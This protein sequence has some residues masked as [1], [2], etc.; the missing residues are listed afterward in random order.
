MR[1]LTI[2]SFRHR[3]LAQARASLMVYEGEPDKRHCVTRSL[4]AGMDIGP[5][6][7]RFHRAGD[8]RNKFNEVVAG[9]QKYGFVIEQTI[10]T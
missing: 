7:W 5:D 1:R 9:I 8:A 2:H 10:E 4:P 3:D 6:I